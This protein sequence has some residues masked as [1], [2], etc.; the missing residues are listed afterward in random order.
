MS[1]L[2]PYDTSEVRD[3][4]MKCLVLLARSLGWN[5]AKRPNRPIVITSRDGHH[6]QIPTTTSVRASVFQSTLLGIEHHTVDREPSDEL[7]EEIIKTVKPNREI[8]RR[9]RLSVGTDREHHAEAVPLGGVEPPVPLRPV[10]DVPYVVTETT[11]KAHTSGGKTYDSRVATER[12]WSDGRTDFKCTLCDYEGATLM[13]VSGHFKV[14]VQRG[15]AVKSPPLSSKAVMPVDPAYAPKQIH[16]RGASAMVEAIRIIV[17][18]DT[19]KA[20]ERLQARV[21]DLEREN[22]QLRDDWNA[23]QDLIGGRKR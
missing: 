5:I 13:A 18:S 21:D 12:Q 17:G 7:I 23:L 14:H 4:G 20:V 11:A 15:E 19:E 6:M 1:E 8:A 10:D 2:E 3:D 22:K 9:L 16:I